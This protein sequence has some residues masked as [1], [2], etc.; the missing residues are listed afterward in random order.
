M[1]REYKIVR[2]TVAID[3]VQEAK[4]ETAVNLTSSE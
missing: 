4:S 2:S 3:Q 1:D